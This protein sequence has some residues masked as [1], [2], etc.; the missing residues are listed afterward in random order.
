MMLSDL[1]WWPGPFL[2][3]QGC[4]RYSHSILSIQ[5][6]LLAAPISICCSVCCFS[7]RVL[8]CKLWQWSS[9]LTQVRNEPSEADCHPDNPL[10]SWSICWVWLLTD[11]RQCFEGGLY[12]VQPEPALERTESPLW[13]CWA[14]FS[15]WRH[16]LP[17]LPPMSISPTIIA[18][19]YPAKSNGA[20]KDLTGLSWVE[21]P[22][23]EICNDQNWCWRYLKCL[24]AHK[25]L[26]P[27]QRHV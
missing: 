15:S 11:H 22:F 2:W 1:V 4:H 7:C 18:Q 25:E 20:P 8:G 21:K 10:Y 26:I 23:A 3:S 16:V 24:Y 27:I 9:D 19:G 5:K 12:L 6:L 13:H 17:V 14:L